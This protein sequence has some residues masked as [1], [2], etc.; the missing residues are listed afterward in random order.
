MK[1]TV[2]VLALTILAHAAYGQAAA[3]F[4]VASIKTASPAETE[5]SLTHNAGARLT[6]SNATLKMLILLAYQVMPYQVSGGPNW[7]ESDGFDIEAKAAN[8]KATQAQFRQ[9][10]QRLLA[11]RFQLKVH[12]GAAELPVYALVA[13]KGGARLVEAKNDNAEVS[14]NIDGPGHMTGVKATMPML[15]N[16]LTRP[17]QR[18]VVDET[19]LAGAYNFELRFLPDR[20]PPRPGDDAA[21]PTGDG[22]SLFTALQEQLGLSLKAGKGPV[23]VLVIDHAERPSEN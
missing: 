2:P 8:P 17:L 20:K 23:E 11:D 21:P 9:M 1:R 22:P 14:M 16:T 6:T 10:I 7:L 12:M 4:E 13:A 15:A 3:K 19:G 5:R 18:K